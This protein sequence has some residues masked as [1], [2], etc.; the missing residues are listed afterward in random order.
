MRYTA[1]C[2]IFLLLSV[3]LNAQEVLNNET[4]LKLVKAGI[5]EE[6]IVS[7]VNQQPGKYSLSAADIIALKAGGVSDRV[8]AA[9]IVRSAALAQPTAPLPTTSSTLKVAVSSQPASQSPLVLHDGTP[10]TLRLNRTLTSADAKAGDNVDF[11]VL[12][13]IKVDDAMLIPRGG[14]AIATITEAEHKRRMARGGKLDVNMDYTRLVTGEKVALRAVKEVK[15]G[16]HTGAMTGAIVATAIV[17]WPAAPFFLFMHGKDVT[18][19]KGTEIT[20]YVNGEIKLDRA[21]FVGGA[22][23]QILVASSPPPMPVMSPATFTPTVAPAPS[24]PIVG[25]LVDIT[26]TSTPANAMLTANSTQ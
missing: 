26:F 23:A 4:I 1:A 3:T 13:D 5:G 15:G 22:P 6:V 9:V 24:N 17:V 14:T 21:R 7:M 20:A 25:G 10:V 8:I 11:E 18:I 16:G 19:P 2:I 12:D